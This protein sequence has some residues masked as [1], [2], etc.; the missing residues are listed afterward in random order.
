MTR[1]VEDPWEAATF[2]GARRAQIRRMMGLSP[3]QRL[4]AMIELTQTAKQLAATPRR[5]A[6]GSEAP[7]PRVG[8][9]ET[10]AHYHGGSPSGDVHTLILSGCTPIPLASYLKALGIL[11]LVAEQADPDARGYWQ[12]ERFVLETELGREELAQF[13]L[14]A[15][16]PTPVLAPWNGGSGFYPKDNKDGIEPLAATDAG[17][18]SC[19]GGAIRSIQDILEEEGYEERPADEA[20]AK[21]LSKLRAELPD[22]ALEWLDA[23]VLLTEEKPFYPPLLGTGGNDG[24]L[25]FTNNFMRRLVTVFTPETGEPRYESE[26]WLSEALFGTTRPG[27]PSAKVGQFAPGDAGGP[28]QVSGFDADKPLV[29]PWDFILMLEGALLFAAA[30]TRRLE[31]ADPGALSYPFTVRSTGAGSGG[32]GMDEEDNAR[33]EF[34]AP[35]WD[36]PVGLEELRAVLREGRVTLGRRPAR[37]GLDFVRAVSQLGVERGISGFQRYAFLMRSGKAFFATPLNRVTVQRNP[38]AELVNDLDRNNWLGRFRSYARRN[39]ANRIVS[40][41]R[42]LEDAI[43]ELSTRHEKQ[44]ITLQRLLVL[45]GKI[46]LY[47]ARSPRARNLNE[48][49]CPPVPSLSE[50]WFVDTQDGSAELEIAASLAG[51]HAINHHGARV[52]RMRL[53]LAP[54]RDSPT[55]AWA[56]DD[57]HRVSWVANAS[58][59][60]NVASLLRRRLL[61]AV[62]ADLPDKPFEGWWRSPLANVA[63]LLSG[64]LDER[65]ITALLPGLMLVRLPPGSGRGGERETPLPAAYRLLKP[66]FCTDHQLQRSK[67]LESGRSLP[68]KADMIRRLEADDVPGALELARRRLAGAGIRPGFRAMSPGS[69]SGPPLLAA[70][71]VPISDYAVQALLPRE[72]HREPETEHAKDN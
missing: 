50:R 44:Q 66:F 64:V 62:Q 55:P 19:I 49:G 37:D 17:R 7:A 71:A 65:R 54:E 56:G 61:D 9:A 12:N 52:L 27:I 46:Q 31:T 15:Y 18:L 34:W 72:Q 67:L 4:E 21:L 3:R 41:A 51:L 14:E 53:H 35:L 47:F 8:V 48:G 26:G 70:L 16:R 59:A 57:T 11:R 10:E 25:D 28:N 40:L 30:T 2:E 45:L 5:K 22:Q 60:G 69:A 63:D 36:G 1:N 32:T 29:N 68:L 20:K 23:A 42:R 43:F 6:G 39:G 24:R 33:N 38:A 58:L 13:L